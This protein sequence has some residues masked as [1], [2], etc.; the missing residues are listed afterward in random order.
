ML[1]HVGQDCFLPESTS[2]FVPG[3]ELT[4]PHPEAD[5]QDNQMLGD[6]VRLVDYMFQAGFWFLSLLA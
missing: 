1:E 3:R 4:F 2:A 5:E 6:C